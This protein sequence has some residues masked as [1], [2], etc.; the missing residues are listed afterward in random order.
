MTRICG[1]LTLAVG[2]AVAGCA[3]SDTTGWMGSSDNATN[4]GG[5]RSGEDFTA[6]RYGHLVNNNSYGVDYGYSNNGY[7]TSSY[8]SAYNSNSSYNRSHDVNYNNNSNSEMSHTTGT[9]DNPQ[10]SVSPDKNPMALSGT[11]RRF[12]MDVM[13]GG[14]YEVQAG[15]LAL[16]KASDSRVKNI[17]QHMVDDHTKANDQL[18][19]LATR[20]G[21]KN[22]PGMN[23]DQL[24]MIGRL[25]QLNGADFDREYL[26]QQQ[27]AHQ[28]TITKFQS[29]AN[30]GNDRDLRDWASATLPTLRDHLRMINDVRGGNN[31]GMEK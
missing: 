17:A 12:V 3:T 10:V 29:E 13:A 2:L 9:P 19:A 20:K 15:N 14:T 4:M 8:N 6:D 28:D 22:N 16:T 27:Q 24:S 23:Q 7:G 5:M 26:S 31:M 21:I 11:D 25:N 1:I 18:T 30:S